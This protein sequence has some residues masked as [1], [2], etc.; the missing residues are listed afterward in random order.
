MNHDLSYNKYSLMFKEPEIEKKYRLKLL[1]ENIF[2]QK[3][4]LCNSLVNSVVVSALIF[5]LNS[6][7]IEEDL[8]TTVIAY[9]LMVYCFALSSLLVLSFTSNFE[10]RF[11]KLKRIVIIINEFKYIIFFM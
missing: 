4:N 6:Q 9:C 3:L 8:S 5:V 7:N 2:N 1:K 11:D 10:K